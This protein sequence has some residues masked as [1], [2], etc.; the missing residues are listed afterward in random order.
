MAYHYGHEGLEE[1]QELFDGVV[2]RLGVAVQGRQEADAE[3]RKSGLLVDLAG[4]WVGKKDGDAVV[5]T[6]VAELGSTYTRF[7]AQPQA[8]DGCFPDVRADVD[9]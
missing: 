5:A 8:P 9:V 7:T 3:V 1:N 4:S 6:V 2:R